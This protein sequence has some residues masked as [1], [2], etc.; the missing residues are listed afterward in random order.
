M[1]RAGSKM[2]RVDEIG[3]GYV[4]KASV[5]VNA[6]PAK[7]WGPRN[8]WKKVL[9]IPIAK[10]SETDNTHNRLAELGRE[11]ALKVHKVQADFS[12]EHN[13]GR[14]R[15]MIRESLSEQISETTDLT[16]QILLSQANKKEGL[17][18]YTH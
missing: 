7:V 3:R 15:A 5:S 8:I 13:I 17:T 14:L 6:P 9:E 16:S 10:F 1:L 18:A 12:E 2:D 11:C 4:A